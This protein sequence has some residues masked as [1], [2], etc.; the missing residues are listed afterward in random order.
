MS[1]WLRPDLCLGVTAVGLTAVHPAQTGLLDEAASALLAACLV[2][3][4]IREARQ[5]EV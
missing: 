2:S 3:E 4:L 5:A 1:A